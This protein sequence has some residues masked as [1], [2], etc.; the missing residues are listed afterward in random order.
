VP[1]ASGIVLEI[2]VGSGLN[3]PFHEATAKR[4]RA[5]DSAEELLTMAR[6][7]VG[8]ARVSGRGPCTEP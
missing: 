8:V 5:L 1:E 4:L 3:L 2:G 7:K 6:K